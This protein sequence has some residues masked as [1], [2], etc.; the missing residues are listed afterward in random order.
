MAEPPFADVAAV[1]IG[2]NEGARLDACLR[3]LLPQASRVVYV[4]SGSTDGSAEA[5]R[6]LGAEVVDLDLTVPFT[7][8]RAR[9][10]GVARL[11]ETG[12]LPSFLQFVDGDCILDE[13]WIAAARETLL[14]DPG[15]AVVCG[16]RRERFPGASV[17]NRLI[18]KEWDT[19]V[20]EAAA[21]GGDSLM[22]ADAFRAVGGFNPTVICGEEPELCVRLRAAGWRIRRIDREMTLHDAALSRFGQ[23][24]RR[25]IRTGYA[26]A[27]GAHLHGAPPERH[28]VRE[29]RRALLWGG[30][31][32]LAILLLAV[33]VSPWALLGLAVY[34]LQILRLSLRTRDPADALLM[35]V[36]KFAEVIGIARFRRDRLSGRAARIIEYK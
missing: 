31:L 12:G 4:D 27:I 17:Y 8:A 11:E 10:A 32:P 16:R 18:D 2:R 22:R 25:A 36:G 29:L 7:A 26:Y 9:N 21:C 14:A 1:A 3:S 15:L 19:P 20:G 23:W 13:G 28:S 35:T 33:T 30:A 5:A 24:W 6:D 34:P